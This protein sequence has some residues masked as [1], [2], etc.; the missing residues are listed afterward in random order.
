[1]QGLNKGLD[2]KC[3]AIL[4]QRAQGGNRVARGKSG[5]RDTREEGGGS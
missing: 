4:M 2:S 5:T 3:W 1:M